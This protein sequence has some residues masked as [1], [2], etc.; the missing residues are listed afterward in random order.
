MDILGLPGRLLDDGLALWPD[1]VT[2]LA[3]LIQ[4]VFCSVSN[5]QHHHLATLNFMAKEQNWKNLKGSKGH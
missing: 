4:N 2:T 3:R 1:L 5:S